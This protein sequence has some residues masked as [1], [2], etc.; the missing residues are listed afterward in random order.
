MP[1]FSEFWDNKVKSAA[2]DVCETCKT[3]GCL[4]F[5]V[6]EMVFYIE[7]DL[8]DG[9]DPHLRLY[10]CV[11]TLNDE[12]YYKAVHGSTDKAEVEK[13]RA[14]GKLLTELFNFS[15]KETEVHG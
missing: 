8:A 14:F 9:R 1:T 11:G 13:L 6:S 2:K 7:H 12:G 15:F 4:G 10:P 3:D 5:F